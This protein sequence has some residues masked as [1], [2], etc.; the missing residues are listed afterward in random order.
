[1]LIWVCALHCEAKPVID[2]YRLQKESGALPFDI[3]RA[4][5]MACVVSGI[6]KLAAAAATASTAEKMIQHRSLAWIN[7]G[8]AGAAGA[9]LGTTYLVNKCIDQE[10]H[11]PIYPAIIGQ[12]SLNTRGCLTV[13]S[14]TEDFHE[15][16]LHDME[17]SG[18]MQA[19][20]YYSS[21]ELVHCIKVV[22][23][24]ESEK[25]GKDRQQTS[26]L[27][28]S[29]MQAINQQAEQLIALNQ[30]LA[31]RQL[32]DTVLAAFLAEAHYTETRK[33]QLHQLLNYLLNRNFDADSLLQRCK[34]LSA[35]EVI[36]QLQ[37]FSRADSSNL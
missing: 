30:Q 12:P 28:A 11:Q 16:H 18:F 27:I 37:R 14:P 15:R 19:A 34:Q 17:A 26:S 24:N 35:A 36:N 5:N 9:A 6:G 13:P 4:D 25:T 7:L 32:D 20:L 8:V 21:S 10:T 29:N 31:E 3:Y 22:S 33:H 2:Y 23:D 1:M